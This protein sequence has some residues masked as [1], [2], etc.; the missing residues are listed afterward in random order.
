MAH[1]ITLLTDF[2]SQDGYT[3]AMRGYLLTHAP[4]AMVHEVSHDIT[5][6]DVWQAALALKRYARQFP[7]PCVHLVVV[8]PGVGSERQAL[9]LQTSQ[10]HWLIGP[11]N[12]VLSLAAETYSDITAYAIKPQ[13]PW[14]RKHSSFD[15]L[16]LFA[17]AAAKLCDQNAPLE[18]MLDPLSQYHQLSYPVPELIG[19]QLIGQIVGFDRFGNA[20]TNITKADLPQGQPLKAFCGHLHFPLCEFYCA[21]EAH[22]RLALFNSDNVL[23]LAVYQGSAQSELQLEVGQNLSISL[24][25]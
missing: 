11:D 6:Q 17:P 18:D 20:L 12:G 19:Q 7:N 21:A 2:G 1:H 16:A 4:S 8:D 23:E 22:G 5:P 14:W 25:D 13:T 15:G 3:A 10:G 9:A 24:A